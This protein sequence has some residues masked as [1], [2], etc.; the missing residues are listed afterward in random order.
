MFEKAVVCTD[1][2]EDSD[3]L[4]GCAGEL[5]I[6]G[7]SEAILTHVVDVFGQTPTCTLAGPEADQAFERQIATLEDCGI[8]VH[9]EA[10]IGHPAFS[11]EEVR[12]RHGATLIVVGSHGKGVFDTPFSGSVSSDLLQLSETPVLVA[13]F[14]GLAREGGVACAT[15]LGHVLYC[16]DFSE[17]AGRAFSCLEELAGIGAREFT[18]MHVQDKRRIDDEGPG[19]LPEYDRR[20][21]L[22]LGHLRERLMTA[23]ATTARIEVVHG[24]PAEK[25]AEAAASGRYSLIVLGARGR[26][27][28]DTGMLGGVSDRVVRESHT[29]IL[30][31]PAP[32]G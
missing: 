31:V 21:T 10:P 24:S 8:V 17:S 4:V 25:V 14:A 19:L 26:S 6:L 29:P 7:I 30:L 28:R 12:Q 3:C 5:R 15:I 20:D 1:L 23:G 11:L 2:S 13:S 27:Q 32:L 9:V 16:T 18:L 22:R